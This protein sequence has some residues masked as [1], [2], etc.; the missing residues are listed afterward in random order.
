MMSDVALGEILTIERDEV[1]L[2]PG[3][4]YR[5]AGIYSFGRGAFERGTIQGAETS[6]QSLFRLHEDQVVLSRLNG[7]EGAVDVVDGRLAGCFVSNE[8]P[9]FSVNL[10]RADPAFV[11][12][13][14]RWPT[15]WDRLVPRGSMVRRKRVQ[16][17]Q[18]LDVRIPLPPI[19]EQRRIAR[20]IDRLVEGLSETIRRSARAAILT[21]RLVDGSAKTMIWNPCWPLH[22]LGDIAV[23]NPRPAGLDASDEVLFV[24]MAA[25]AA[26]TGAIAD[27]STTTAGEV[28]LGYKQFRR[29]DVIFARITPCMQNGKSAI[30]T[31][32][33]E[34][35]YGSTEFHVVRPGPETTAIW[36]HCLMRTREFRNMAAERFTGTAGQQRVP[37]A[38]LNS[39]P[40]PLPPIQKQIELVAGV[41]RVEEAGRLVAERRLTAGTLTAALLPSALNQVFSGIS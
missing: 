2:E 11:R 9:T 14:T 27:A 32:K 37:A 17:A 41:D 8:Y 18:F 36:L 24:P 20:E 10:Q 15:F 28:G 21:E 7:W 6:Y 34:Y 26:A 13:I 25:V 33:S 12:W 31:G 30:Y 38:F 29:G 16:P 35:A 23:V 5:T 3:E 39:V 22:P 19:E 4:F 1:V 40:I